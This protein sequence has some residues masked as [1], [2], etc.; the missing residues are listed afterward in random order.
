MSSSPFVPSVESSR[1][2][3]LVLVVDD[4]APMRLLLRKQ[5]E[6]LGLQVETAGDADS[7][8]R[9]L[10][11]REVALVITDICMPGLDGIELTAWV[12][13]HSP[14]TEVV[15]VTG[16]ASIQSATRAVHLGA[17]DYLLKPFGDIARI[18]AAIVRALERRAKRLREARAQHAVSDGLAILLDQLPVGIVLTDARSRP[19]FCNAA[20]RRLLDAGDGVVISSDGRFA[21]V[22]RRDAATLGELMSEASDPGARGGALLVERGPGRADLHVLVTPLGNHGDHSTASTAL[23]WAV[24][25]GDPEAPVTP[26]EGALRR[27]FDLS[28][29]EA[30]VA[31]SLMCGRSIDETAAL[32]FVSPHTVRTHVKRILA[33]TGTSRQGELISL[34]LRGPAI[35]SGPARSV[36]W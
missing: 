7:A 35:V 3:E 15:L 20:A 6:D 18:D 30:A 16:H 24:F 21:P 1:R 31:S 25:L 27:W 12:K 8:Q 14:D 19:R 34:L 33:K 22:H 2:A 23:S 17:S 11:R 32:L 26:A 28:A 4:E 13:E 10:E 29:A 36:R 5:A 9:M